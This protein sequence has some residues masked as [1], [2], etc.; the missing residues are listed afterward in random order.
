MKPFHLRARGF[1]AALAAVLLVLCLFSGCDAAAQA[2]ASAAAQVQAESEA[3]SQTQ[4]A[5]GETDE[6]ADGADDAGSENGET[7]APEEDGEYSAPEDVAAYL[8]AYGRLPGNFITKDQAKSLGWNS[9]A[10]NLWDVADGMSIGGDHYGN[11]EGGLPNAEGRKWRECDVNY[12]G[13]HRGAERILYS[14]D[15]LIYYTGDH[16]KTFTQLYG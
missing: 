8:H 12:T 5:T 4:G 2:V 14:N 13:G 6:N 7:A 11:Y 15:G 1:L 9:A 10:G 16:Y 3:V